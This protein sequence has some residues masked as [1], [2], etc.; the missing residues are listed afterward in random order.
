MLN[1]RTS[2]EA[3]IPQND[4]DVAFDVLVSF[5]VYTE[6]ITWNQHI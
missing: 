1:L 4:F 5:Q 2:A 3:S 6:R